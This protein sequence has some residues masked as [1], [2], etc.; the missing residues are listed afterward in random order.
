M[1]EDNRGVQTDV[2]VQSNDTEYCECELQR[3]NTDNF[4][5]MRM[6]FPNDNV[7][8]SDTNSLLQPILW[9]HADF[10]SPPEDSHILEDIIEI[11]DADWTP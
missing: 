8:L 10:D 11:L 4:D 1:A 5:T 7:D 6:N 3:M 2:T 9:V